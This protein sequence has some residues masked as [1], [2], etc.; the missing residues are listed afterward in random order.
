MLRKETLNFKKSVH[1]SIYE[2]KKEKNEQTRS[3]LF[4]NLGT[5]PFGLDGETLYLPKYGS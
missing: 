2:M 3:S 1:V 4:I 5:K